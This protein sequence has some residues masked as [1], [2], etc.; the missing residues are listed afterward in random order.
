[1]GVGHLVCG[2]QACEEIGTDA[3]QQLPEVREYKR[4]LDAVHFAWDC[5]TGWA[6]G[7]TEG[8]ILVLLADAYTAKLGMCTDLRR[9]GLDVAVSKAAP[10]E[11]IEVCTYA[12]W[13][14]CFC[15]IRTHTGVAGD[16]GRF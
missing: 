10:E 1:M 8:T 13:C 16:R 6:D 5:L 9:V 15:I 11:T 3:L 14:M 2:W 7:I 4:V 12:P